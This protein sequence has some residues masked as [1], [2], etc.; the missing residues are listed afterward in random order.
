MYQGVLKDDMNDIYKSLKHNEYVER[1]IV[2]CGNLKQYSRYFENKDDLKDN[3][4]GLEP[5]LS[6]RI[7]D[8][9]SFDLKK[10]WASN[11]ITPVVKKYVLSILN[12][13][14]LDIHRIYDITT[15][16]DVDI[17]KFT[18]VLMSSIGQL[19]KQ[20]GLHRCNSAFNRIET[21][22]EL[23][24]SKFTGYYRESIA[25]ANPNMLIESFII[26]VSNQGSANAT[27]TREFRQIIQYMHKISNNAGKNQDPNIK[28]LFAILN[29]NF[30]VVEKKTL[31]ADE[32]KSMDDMDLT[33]K[34]DP[35]DPTLKDDPA[36]LTL[37]EESDDTEEK[38][39]D[40][41]DLTD[42]PDSS[43]ILDG[44]ANISITKE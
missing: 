1:F 27:L 17:D 16:P 34:D 9:S 36:D 22:V 42:L 28:K 33:L 43:N 25:S 38:D 15:S 44:I 23:L 30:A 7:F 19:R 26:D 31:P 12:L 35:A 5:G 4:I 14:Y 18:T 6:F 13:L 37:N 40:L 24:K 8:F 39:D 20:P 41:P 29:K 3:F 2:L 11:R 21:S 32:I 10:L